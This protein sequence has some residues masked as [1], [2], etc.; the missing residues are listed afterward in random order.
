MAAS[1]PITGTVALVTA[2]T[3]ALALLWQDYQTF[4]AGGDTLI[5][6]AKWEPGITAAK[7]GLTYIRDLLNDIFYRAFSLGGVIAG[8]ISGDRNQIDQAFDQL[9]NGQRKTPAAAAAGP[10]AEEA[11]SMTQKALQYFQNQGW[12]AAN[13]ETESKFN[14]KAVGDNGKA[15]GLAQWHPDRQSEFKKAFGKDITDSSFAEQLA[16]IQ[17]E[18]T[19]GN[20]KSAGD[21][22]RAT[23]TPQEAAEAVSRYYER[24]AQ[25]DKQAAMRGSLGAAMA[26]VPGAARAAMGAGSAPTGAGAAPASSTEV[27]NSNEVHVGEVHIHTSASDMQGAG[28]DMGRGLNNLF[29]ANANYGAF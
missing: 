1:I 13:I 26:G 17:Y 11:T 25:K 3:G 21:K 4:K 18:L 15:Y 27:S 12:I 20:E 6:W 8:V 29:T 16:F 14:P 9:L 7:E 10:S 24:P 2:L 19:Q 5:D 23:T 22:L 28:S